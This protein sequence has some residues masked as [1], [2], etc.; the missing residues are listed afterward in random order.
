MLFCTFC[1]TF[2]ACTDY[3]VLCAILCS[4]Q[5]P[6]SHRS[7]QTG[8]QHGDGIKNAGGG[9]LGDWNEM[10][11]HLVSAMPAH[12]LML[13]FPPTRGRE[14]PQREVCVNSPC[15]SPLFISALTGSVLIEIQIKINSIMCFDFTCVSPL[16]FMLKR[17][18]F[19]LLRDFRNFL[20][21]TLPQWI[22]LKFFFRKTDY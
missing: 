1:E 10:F 21:N 5:G 16:S 7:S 3:F 18:I 2:A 13:H 15:L 9:D 4:D 11:F 6:G 12:T 19:F 8:S 22:Y 14:S 17:I 20:L